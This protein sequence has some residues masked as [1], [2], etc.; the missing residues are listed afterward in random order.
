MMANGS[1]LVATMPD[2]VVNWLAETAIVWAQNN[3]VT[4]NAT[5]WFF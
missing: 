2:E 5:E 4:D 1:S 3:N